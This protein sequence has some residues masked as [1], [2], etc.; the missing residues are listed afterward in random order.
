[1]TQIKFHY[2]SLTTPNPLMTIGARHS[3]RIPLLYRLIVTS[4]MC[5]GDFNILS[6]E[7]LVDK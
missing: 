7:Q 1:M 2:V 4:T 3:P 5:T 6:R